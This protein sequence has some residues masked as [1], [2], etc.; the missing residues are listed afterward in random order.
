MMS[1]GFMARASASVMPFPSV[2]ITLAIDVDAIADPHPNVF[3]L[4]SLMR[5]VA[6]STFI[7]T[8]SSSPQ[9]GEPTLPIALKAA[10]STSSMAK[11]FGW[12][13]CSFTASE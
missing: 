4:K 1:C 9:A 5:L 11:F 10:V 8:R 7:H 13:K 3:H 2:T 6:G 12:K